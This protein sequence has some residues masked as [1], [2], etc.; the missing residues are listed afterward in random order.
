MP[1]TSPT[2]QDRSPL[3]VRARP[4]V[5]AVIAL[6]PLLG[7]FPALNMLLAPRDHFAFIAGCAATVACVAA[8]AFVVTLQLRLRAIGCLLCLDTEGITVH[9]QPTV[10]WSDLREVRAQAGTKKQPPAVVF[11]P[12]PGI[13][14]PTLPT[15]IPLQRPHARAQAFTK[16]YGSPLVLHPAGMNATA[17]QILTAVQRLSNTP[18]TTH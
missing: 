13:T 1:P 18:L 6:S 3:E 17:P 7:L 16:R 2:G 15:G 14:L 11:V 12:R 10:P 9:G 5:F 8:S 4:G